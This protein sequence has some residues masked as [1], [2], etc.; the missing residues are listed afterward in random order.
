MLKRNKIIIS[1]RVQG[2]FFRRFIFENAVNLGL[3]GYVKNRNNE[4]VEA[5]FEGEETDLKKI[6]KLCKKGPAGAKVENIKVI[7]KKIKGEKEFKKL[8]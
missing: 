2:V 7:E 5:V 6:I 8:G 4:K 3:K 1:G